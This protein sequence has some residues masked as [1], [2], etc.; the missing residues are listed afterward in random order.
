LVEPEGYAP[1]NRPVLCF[2]NSGANHHVGP[3]RSYVELSR[4]LASRGYATF[5]FDIGGLGDSRAAPDEPLIRE[6]G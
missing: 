2:L 4:Q 5:R 1:R 3:H 6:L